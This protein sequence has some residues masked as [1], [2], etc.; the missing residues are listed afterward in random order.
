MSVK[1]IVSSDLVQRLKNYKCEN[2]LTNKDLGRMIGLSTNLIGV[3]LNHC[4]GSEM[5]VYHVNRIMKSGP[6]PRAAERLKQKNS[7]GKA[8]CKKDRNHDVYAIVDAKITSNVR[9]E[10][11]HD[12]SKSFS[13]GCKRSMGKPVCVE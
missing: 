4:R 8:K 5:T 12:D 9:P 7:D 6:D 10:T 1:N 2:F 13:R 11:L 3:L